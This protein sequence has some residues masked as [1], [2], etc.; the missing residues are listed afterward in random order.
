M[1]LYLTLVFRFLLAVSVLAPGSEK[2]NDTRELALATAQAISEAE[3]L[4]KNDESREKTLLLVVAVEFRESGFRKHAISN[5]NDHCQM[6]INAR[7]DLGDDSLECVRV[8]IKML[9]ESMRI[10]P[11]DPIAF[12]AEGP[13]GITS[14]RAARISRDR[15]S[16]AS[17]LERTLTRIER[18]SFPVPMQENDH[19]E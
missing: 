17:H 13:H 11:E 9:R 2:K 19:G 1:G 12:Y 14:E 7:P 8:G 10:H 18:T 6:Q 4:F 15:M 16:I 5:T 3:P